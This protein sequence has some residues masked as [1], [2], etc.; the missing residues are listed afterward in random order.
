MYTI[1]YRCA[2]YII[3]KNKLFAHLIIHLTPKIDFQIQGE[4]IERH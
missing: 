1:M 3:N 4:N 2:K